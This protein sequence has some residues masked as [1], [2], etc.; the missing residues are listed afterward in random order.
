MNKRKTILYVVLL[1]LVISVM[2]ASFI[3][4]NYNN[5]FMCILTLI[6]FLIPTIIERRLNIELPTAL[7]CLIII[8]IFSAEILGEVS[9]YYIKIPF[10][11]SLLHTLNGFIMAA[12]GFSMIDILNSSPKLH[13]DMSPIFVA[14][15][16][17]CF[18]MTIGVLWE[19]FEY[20]MDIFAHTDMQKDMIIEAISSVYINPDMANEAIIISEIPKTI[21]EGSVNGV[22]TNTI[23]KSGYLDIGLHDT[24]G[25]LIVNCIGALTFSVAGIL[26]IKG[27]G[28][29]AK[30]FIPQ[31]K[32]SHNE[33]KT[34]E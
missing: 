9:G 32:P 34:K 3:S 16:S 14:F 1:I 18:S 8:F 29:L 24:M 11:D 27:R 19:F 17:F 28:R 7:E 2:T 21:I 4:K 6:L 12:I 5:A 30:N 31:L 26:Y 15:V 33:D 13:F 22:A 10:W 23:I 25:D 20:G